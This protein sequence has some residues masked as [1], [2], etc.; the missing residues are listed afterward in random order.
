VGTVQNPTT[1][2]VSDPAAS[3]REC[4]LMVESSVLALPVGVGYTS[5]ARARGATTVSDRSAPSN[6][7]DRVEQAHPPNPSA[8]PVLR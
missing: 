3:G 6:P 2:R 5:T 8:P 1:A 4:E 7:F